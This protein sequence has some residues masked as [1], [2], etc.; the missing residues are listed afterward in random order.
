M[1]VSGGRAAK[2]RTVLLF[3]LISMASYAGMVFTVNTVYLYLWFDY[4]SPAG[5]E[6]QML[7]SF[8]GGMLY[9]CEEAPQCIIYDLR[10]GVTVVLIPQSLIDI[11]T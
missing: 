1:T 10:V 5:F 6:T 8:V 4:L 11:Q 3:L 2:W 7:H 9:H